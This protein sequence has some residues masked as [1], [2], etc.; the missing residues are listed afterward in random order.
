MNKII[1][2]KFF[3]CFIDNFCCYLIVIGRPAIIFVEYL[4]LR[5]AKLSPILQHQKKIKT[6][7]TFIFIVELSFNKETFLALK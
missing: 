5:L 7:I 3:V 4:D 1:I 2:S 6:D